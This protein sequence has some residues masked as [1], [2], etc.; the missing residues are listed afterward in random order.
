MPFA[1]LRT[2]AGFG[3]VNRYAQ[4]S[5]RAARSTAIA[6]PAPVGHTRMPS[7]KAGESPSCFRSSRLLMSYSTST[8][9]SGCDQIVSPVADDNT[10]SRICCRSSTRTKSSLPSGRGLPKNQREL[11]S[12]P[13]VSLLARGSCQRSCP[14]CEMS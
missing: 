14:F 9:A 6:A 12:S 3:I 10:S 2:S 5:V 4:R 7:A 1:N 13:V 11:G 8:S